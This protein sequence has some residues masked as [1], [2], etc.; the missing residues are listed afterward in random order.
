[1]C[2]AGLVLAAGVACALAP[3]CGMFGDSGEGRGRISGRPGPVEPVESRIDAVTG[4]TLIVPVRVTGTLSGPGSGPGGGPPVSPAGPN[5]DLS[6]LKVTLDDGTP[7]ATTMRWITVG[8]EDPGALG[9][10][11]PRWLPPAGKWRTFDTPPPEGSLALA[12]MAVDLP[13]NAAGR[14]LLIGSRRVALHWLPSPA[15][16]AAEQGTRIESPIPATLREAP[17]LMELTRPERLSPVRRWRYRLL[18]TGL[19]PALLP[20]AVPGEPMRFADPV[21]EAVAAQNEARWAVALGELSR[22]D[23]ELGAELAGRLCAVVR[24]NSHTVAPVW[25]VDQGDLDSLLS[26]LLSPEAGPLGRAETA[27]QWLKAHPAATSWIIDAAAEEDGAT[28]QP[29]VWIGTTN[30]LP[31]PVVAWSVWLDGAERELGPHPE[32]APVPGMSAGSSPSSVPAEAVVRTRTTEGSEVKSATL[33]V[34][35]GALESRLNVDLMKILARPPSVVIGPLAPDLTLDGFLSGTGLTAA[36]SAWSTSA[37]M[38]RGRPEEAASGAPGRVPAWVLYV[39]CGR[40]ESPDG[41][42]AAQDTVRIWAGPRSKPRMI[43][44]I[45]ESGASERED[46]LGRAGQGAA[47]RVMREKS[48]W[49]AVVT[50]PGDCIEAGGVMRLGIERTDSRGVHSAW[51]RATLP[52]QETPG[53]A[54]FDLAA[55][56]K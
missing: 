24:F 3:G 20:P 53:R 35:V 36:D 19:N 1:M 18:M 10:T 2:R 54:V 37:V 34:H 5:M 55:W 16:L 40:P 21:L 22:T 7:L 28:G 25:P 11:G 42:S 6:G 50:L 4:M 27:R 51:P 29:V 17:S 12:V 26:D 32:M 46:D 43:L 8:K 31:R 33:A 38:Y 44:R 45:E 39:E 23:R 14:D 13:E 15:S 41:E 47:V 48:R 49:I 9:E 30:L 56:D 52:W